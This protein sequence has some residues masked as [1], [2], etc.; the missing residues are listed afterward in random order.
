MTPLYRRQQEVACLQ[1]TFAV[2]SAPPAEIPSLGS[3]LIALFDRSI[4]RRQTK[5]SKVAEIWLALVPQTLSDHCSLQAF[6]RGTLTVIVDSGSHLYELKQLL[7]A[8]LQQQMLLAGSAAGLRKIN[9][10][11]GR[12]Q[13]DEKRPAPPPSRPSPPARTSRTGSRNNRA[14]H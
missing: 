12:W 11:A 10:R 6:T 9:L 2:K 5:L 7:L 1:R 13:D 3:E 8:G 14:S 4:V